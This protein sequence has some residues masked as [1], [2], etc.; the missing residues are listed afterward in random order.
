MMKHYIRHVIFFLILMAASPA[1]Q[2]KLLHPQTTHRVRNISMNDGLSH[3]YVDDIYRDSMG[4]IWIATSGS[5]ARYDGYEFV[6]FHSNSISRNIKSTHVRKVTEDGFGRLWVA[7]DGGIDVIDLK[8]LNTIPP[9]NISEKLSQIINESAGFISTDNAGNIWL[10]NRKDVVCIILDSEGNVEEVVK[11]P[12]LSRTVIS[13]SAIKPVGEKDNGV[14]TSVDGKICHLTIEG[15]KIREEAIAAMPEFPKEVYVGDFIEYNGDLWVATD[16]GLYQHDRFNDIVIEYHGG[17]GED[18][19][20]QDFVTSLALTSEGDLV[21]GTL[22]GFNVF[23]HFDNHFEQVHTSEIGSY[24]GGMGNNF[25]NCLYADGEDLWI[26]TEACGIDLVSPKFIYAELFRH[27]ASDGKSL[28]PNPVNAILEDGD[29]TLWVGTVEGGLNRSLSKDSGFEHFT[30][31]SGTLPHNSVSALAADH[32]GHLWI[33]TWGGG[34]SV[35]PRNN[36]RVAEK[37]ITTAHETGELIF[38]I[39]SLQFDPINNLVWIGANNGLFVYDFATEEVRKPFAESDMVRGCVASLISPDGKLWVGGTEGLY[40]VDLKKKLCGKG[41]AYEKHETKLDNTESR[42]KEKITALAMTKDGAI[43]VGTNGNGL[44]KRVVENGKERFVNYSTADGLPNNVIH[45]IAEDVHG[46][47]WIATY[48]GLSAMTHDGSF[49]NFGKHN[50]L[51]TEQFYWN[52][53]C[54]L[55]NGS[56]LFGSVDGLLLVKGLGGRITDVAFPVVFTSI[57][58]DDG[59]EY[60]GMDRE[61]EISESEKSF[62]VSFSSLDYVN[63]NQGHYYYRLA[64]FDNEWKELPEGR[65]SVTYTNLSAG[66][67]NL[68]VKYVA[69]GETFDDAPVSEFRL[70][71]VPYFYKRWWFILLVAAVLLGCVWIVYKWRVRDLTRQRNALKA[72]VDERVKEINEQKDLIETNARELE[73]QNEELKQSNTKIEEMARTVQK[74]TVDRISFFTNITHEFRTPITLIIGPI[75]RARKL[76]T[77]PK[78][79]EQLSF[80]ERNSK[81]LLSLVNQLMDFRKVESG[82]IDIARNKSNFQKFID[83]LI[84]PFRAFAEE[85]HIEL[86]TIYHLSTPVFSYDEDALRKVIT[87]LIGNAVKFTPDNG[88]IT[89][90]VSLFKSGRCSYPNTLYICVSDTGCGL[91]EEDIPKVFDRFYQGKSSIKYPLIGASDSGIG[92]YLCKRIVEVYGGSITA[93]NNH[94]RGCSFRVLLEVPEEDVATASESSSESRKRLSEDARQATGLPAAGPAPLTILVVEDNRDMRAF[95]R[96]ILADEY[97]VLEAENGEE[98]LRLLLSNDVDFI[99]SDLMMPVMDGMELSR[100]VK[101]NFAISHI[102]F[103]MLTAKTAQESRLEGYKSGVDE[104]LLKP[105]DEEIL[106]AR[107]RNILDNKRRY[108]SQFRQTMEPEALKI[109]EETG[110]KKFIDRIMD[111]VKANYKNSYFEVGDFAEAL[112]V[113][114]SLLNKKMSSLLGEGPNQFVRNYRLKIAKELLEKNRETKMMNVSEIAF[115]VGFNDS[116][117]FTRCFTKQ[118]GVSP[119]SLLK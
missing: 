36:P 114:R 26:G 10:R 85:R 49:L 58:T 57:S 25:I 32:H 89:L 68:E 83:E 76:S 15:N 98:A 64:G 71:V 46:V 95:M 84:P 103:L 73:R 27:D 37:L 30:V 106:L 16:R 43:W 7:S 72:A 119:S 94:V 97:N 111:V 110:D 62:E 31:A 75:E 23:N 14:W 109:P 79:I 56:V 48:H 92:L 112:G 21:A 55:E 41:F 93:R 6:D 87:N 115:E 3:N 61:R 34:I 101:G 90:Y 102:P 53:S 99:I 2:G 63:M 19:I 82:K 113:S 13:T 1:L 28:S 105:F 24:R 22:N 80:V 18:A 52:A 91:S 108:Q 81:Y 5:L 60:L 69:V 51:D 118:Y 33:G 77:N 47:L 50:G 20:T 117:Y 67:Y 104:Y 59:K 38:Y 88:K 54:R 40:I 17:D 100:Q 42:V 29:G 35:V 66:N 44:Y 74:M 39:G 12:H 8:S 78:V 70:N 4:F 11:T 96:S 116:K 65:H 107:I 9:E 86:R 45:G